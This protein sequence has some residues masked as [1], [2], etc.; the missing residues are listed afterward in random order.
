MFFKKPKLE[1]YECKLC[2]REV[3]ADFFSEPFG[4]C[5]TCLNTLNS[6]INSFAMPLIEKSQ[7]SANAESDPANKIMHLQTML[8]VLYE[9]KIK[10]AD[11]GVNAIDGNIEEM[12]KDVVESISQA[13]L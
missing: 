6:F 11:K 5:H 10:Y 4:I 3:T 9:Y 13:R 1:L 8:D 12:I 2:S 7:Q